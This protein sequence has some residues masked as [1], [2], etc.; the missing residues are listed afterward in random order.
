MSARL[1]REIEGEF[2]AEIA[3]PFRIEYRL[4]ADGAIDLLALV[5]L[6]EALPP[7]LRLR[8]TA[9]TVHEQRCLRAAAERDAKRRT[10]Q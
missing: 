10:G 5:P 2:E 9:L 4:D 8:L 3:L 6:S 7:E 1:P